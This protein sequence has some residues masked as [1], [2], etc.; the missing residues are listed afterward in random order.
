MAA[1]ASCEERR[2]SVL[3]MTNSSNLPFKPEEKEDV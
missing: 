1:R 2:D 3:E